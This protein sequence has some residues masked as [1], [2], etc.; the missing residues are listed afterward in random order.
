MKVKIKFLAASVAREALG[1]AFALK[2]LDKSVVTRC[3]L[4]F[5]RALLDYL[6]FFRVPKGFFIGMLRSP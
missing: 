6:W 2:L 4:L 5:L 1:K 3:L